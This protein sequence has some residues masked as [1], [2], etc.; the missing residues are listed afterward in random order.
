VAFISVIIIN[1]ENSFVYRLRDL[2]GHEMAVSSYVVPSGGTL[3]HKGVP[4][5][6]R[7]NDRFGN[8]VIAQHAKAWRADLVITL[9]D[10]WIFQPEVMQHLPWLAWT[11]IDHDPVP[12]KVRSVLIKGGAVA[13]AYSRYGETKMREV[14]IDSLYVPHG[15]NPRYFEAVRQS[16]A[17]KLLG[18]PKSA[19]VVGVVGVNQ[20][21]PNRK[22]LPQII[23]AF[24][25][26]RK[27]HKE[28]FLYLHTSRNR[29]DGYDLDPMLKQF[30]LDE[31]CVKFC[32]PYYNLIG[33]PTRH[34]REVF[35]SFDVLLA[36]F[37]GEGFGLPIIEAQACGVPV[38][39]TEFSSMAELCIYGETVKG[40][41][42]YTKQ[43]AFQRLPRVPDIVAALQKVYGYD[44]DTVK[45]GRRRAK[46]AIRR[47]YDP[48]KITTQYWAPVLAKAAER[49]SMA[50]NNTANAT[51]IPPTRNPIKR[52]ALL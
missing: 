45:A 19:F 32:D 24:A 22:S 3:H 20:G 42:F 50:T 36:P 1:N 6:P 35:T 27:K 4:I 52:R 43:N 38:I 10:Q 39:V 9:T 48:D 21:V 7:G 16:S 23:E 11:P 34:M 15:C 31:S 13:V 14:G 12:P 49:A 18:L 51:T 41:P 25:K 29:N 8:D 47:D 44:S 26:F 17:R 2:L 40:E 33:V 30:D 46:A 37:M 28:A 5:F